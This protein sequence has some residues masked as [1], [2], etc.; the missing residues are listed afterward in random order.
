MAHGFILMINLMP[1][2]TAWVKDRWRPARVVALIH[3]G[4]RSRY[5][6]AYPLIRLRVHAIFGK[7]L[8]DPDQKSVASIS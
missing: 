4:N 8:F 5:R 6:V 7:K 1:K 3:D 2:A